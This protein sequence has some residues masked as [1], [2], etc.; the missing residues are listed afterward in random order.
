LY[1]TPDLYNAE[2]S[3][4]IFNIK[5]FYEKQFIEEGKKI[6]YLSFR[7]TNSGAIKYSVND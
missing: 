1:S 7:L 4:E 3:D 2:I 5:T 6:T